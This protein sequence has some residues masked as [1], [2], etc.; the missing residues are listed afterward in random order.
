MDDI[1][2]QEISYDPCLVP[3]GSEEE[4]DNEDTSVEDY[5]KCEEDEL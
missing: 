2:L 5:W 4:E 1:S 3:M